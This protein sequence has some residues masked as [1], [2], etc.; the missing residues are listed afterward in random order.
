LPDAERERF[1]REIASLQPLGRPGSPAEVAD[2]VAFLL[3]GASRFLSGAVI[4]L[5]GGRSAAGRD[6]EEA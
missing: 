2:V 6:P 5:D 4:P 1:D 3:S